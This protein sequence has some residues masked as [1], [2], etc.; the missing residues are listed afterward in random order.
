MFKGHRLDISEEIVYITRVC[1]EQK[2]RANCSGVHWSRR[3]HLGLPGL[4]RG[5]CTDLKEEYDAWM[6]VKSYSKS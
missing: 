5:V 6:L 2:W 4:V 1:L 3:T